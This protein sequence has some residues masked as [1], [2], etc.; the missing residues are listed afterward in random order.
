VRAKKQFTSLLPPSTAPG[1]FPTEV[2]TAYLASVRLPHGTSLL[3]DT[4]SPNNITSSEWTKDHSRELRAAGLPD[5]S[6]EHRSKPMIC[7]GIGHGT[8]E[9]AWNVAHTICLG[10]GRLDRYVA[11]ELP[12][13][14]TPALLGQRSMKS[15]R[16]L[17][18]TFTGKMYLVGP[19]G[20]E[21]R[22]S[23]G[24]EVHELEES[25][26]GHLMLP[27][28]RFGPQQSQHTSEAQT[29]L[30]G[31]YYAPKVVSHHQPTSAGTRPTCRESFVARRAPVDLAVAD[32]LAELDQLADAGIS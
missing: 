19:G 5:P 3:V 9:A 18:D 21:I 4:G 29:F 23:P 10:N 11:P 30:V 27:C 12:D 16:T 2:E 6:Y 15:L 8:Q 25:P 32:M 26:A 14:R 1:L 24:S 17:I 22:L 13:A 31:D 20:Y 28:S 7:S